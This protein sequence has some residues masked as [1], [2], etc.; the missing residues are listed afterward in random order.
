M[1]NTA[2]QATATGIPAVELTQLETLALRVLFRSS[3]G[4]GHD[5]GFT[6][7]VQRANVME[8]R[9]ISGV[10]SSL[11]KKSIIYVEDEFNGSTQF[12]W[13]SAVTDDHGSGYGIR[14][15]DPQTFDEFCT[16]CNLVPA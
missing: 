4:N 15:E 12:T 2:P 7:K 6:D 11:V 9:Q 8:P 13:G 16:L 1:E 14:G 5:F 3:L 10:I